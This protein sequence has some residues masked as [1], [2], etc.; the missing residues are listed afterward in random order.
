MQS[1]LPGPAGRLKYIT[2]RC[3]RVPW[4]RPAT[5]ERALFQTYSLAGRDDPRWAQLPALGLE[6]NDRSDYWNA[7]LERALAAQSDTHS[8]AGA[9]DPTVFS[10][11]SFRKVL[12]F[13]HNA[14]LECSGCVTP[15]TWAA[16]L[17]HNEMLRSEVLDPLQWHGPYKQRVDAASGRLI[18]ESPWDTLHELAVSST[19]LF[20]VGRLQS[21]LLAAGHQLEERELAVC[22]L[23]PSTWAA[24]LAFQEAAP[25]LEASGSLDSATWACLSAAVQARQAAGAAGLAPDSFGV[26]S[27]GGQQQEEGEEEGWA[28][29]EEEEEQPQQWQQASSLE[30]GGEDGSQPDYA[31]GPGEEQQQ[32][33]QQQGSS[34]GSVS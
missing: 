22:C 33:Q 17:G 19:S 16:L 21:M 30:D 9:P 31:A 34:K 18:H 3:P 6:N 29:G 28:A 7:L 13:Q 23:G 26:G 1:S 4:P 32:Q 2:T 27:V 12:E 20:W 24:L 11:A 15:S 8:S 5:N 14:G 25:G 10:L